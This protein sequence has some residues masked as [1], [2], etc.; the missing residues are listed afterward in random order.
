MTDLPLSRRQFFGATAAAAA[1]GALPASAAETRPSPLAPEPP[2]PL[3][4][5]QRI[6][7]ARFRELSYS[8][9]NSAFDLKFSPDS[10]WLAQFDGR[11]FIGYEVA[12]GRRVKWQTVTDLTTD[13]IHWQMTTGGEV[14]AAQ[15]L[16]QERP[17]YHYDLATGRE[18]KGKVVGFA[19]GQVFTP[20]GTGLIQ[21]DD[22]GTLYRLDVATG[23]TVWKRKWKCDANGVMDLTI[24]A[25]WL[26]GL[27]LKRLSLFDPLTGNDGPPL[28]DAAPK[29]A[30]ADYHFTPLGLSADGQRVAA[31]HFVEVP[32]RI[33][34]WDLS[35]GK[36]VGRPMLPAGGPCFGFA[37][38]GSH[39]LAT[40]DS[41]RL[42]GYDVRTGKIT[43]RLAAENVGQFV[44]SP[45]GR[46]LACGRSVTFLG[47][48]LGGF[49]EDTDG[50]IR[51]LNP[52]TG[53]LLPQSPD[54]SAAV[55]GVRFAGPHTVVAELTPDS[56]RP[57]HLS[58]DVRTGRRRTLSLPPVLMPIHVG[59]AGWAGPR[60]AALSPDG[61][62]YATQVNGRLVVTDAHTRRPLHSS[63]A[64]HDFTD[65][66]PF[67]I[68]RGRVGL[69]EAGRLL[70]WDL[71]A[72]TVRSV[73]LE[74]AA[75]GDIQLATAAT[76]DG[77]TV[78][79]LH[80][81]ANPENQTATLAWVDVPSGK[82]TTT[83][84]EFGQL[85]L[86]ADGQHVAVTTADVQEV[87]G[88][89]RVTVI[90]RDG[91]RTSFRQESR[92]EQP[93]LGAE[94]SACGRTV[95]LSHAKLDLHTQQATPVVQLW[96]VLSGEV[97]VEYATAWRADGLGVSAC[98]R[99]VATTH[100]DAPVYL[101]DV[102]GE[103]TDRQAKPDAKTWDALDAAPDKA[104]TALRRLVQHPAAAVELLSAKL[105][106]AEQ[107]K[108][109]WVKA[110]LDR[111]GSRDFRTRHTAELDLSAVADRVREPLRK[112]IDAGAEN[113]EAEE[114]LQRLLDRSAGVPRSTWRA[115]RAV[116]AL[117]Y[118]EGKPAVELLKKLAGGV[119][120][121]VLTTEAKA[122]VKRRA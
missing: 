63:P 107:P 49:I 39:V 42:V 36:V 24:H 40:D 77:R 87:D 102:F 70:C 10:K 52:A 18:R 115:V 7:S 11:R 3:G 94:L 30:P 9:A 28:E 29:D 15:L 106:P 55:Q 81:D 68:D 4:V 111:L 67:W 31:V 98:G 71:A 22:R 46:T 38:D 91:R 14:L 33:V 62:R 21:Y 73:P 74:F 60:P 122:A 12:T 80:S 99:R 69:V 120:S 110:R 27:G 6:G 48:G 2:P 121:A 104:F 112:A 23:K 26:V 51:L 1:L 92:F 82:V 34:V 59:F 47:A 8:A 105:T 53:E 61:T 79:L 90:G 117:E 57:S 101:W 96:E 16:G 5:C 89:I 65:R 84:G 56:T 58:W 41:N 119:E 85:S 66:D 75:D 118:C 54:P 17:I 76:P 45:D 19:H 93:E 83:R 114:R 50:I 25:G 100:R 103:T 109:E 20:D 97:R 116:E 32:E 43:R 37:A 113:L 88:D 95:F 13:Q 108:A 72:R 64:G 78:L 44:L 86:S 35:T